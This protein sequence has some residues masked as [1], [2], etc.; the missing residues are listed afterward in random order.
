ML[1]PEW[2]HPTYICSKKIIGEYT[3]ENE[4]LLGVYG[5]HSFDCAGLQAI[6][7]QTDMKAT[8]SI[9]KIRG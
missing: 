9:E 4:R 2:Y 1:V 6:S 3:V 8:V 7:I 5:K